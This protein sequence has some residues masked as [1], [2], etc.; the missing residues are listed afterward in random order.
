M[1]LRRDLETVTVEAVFE[2]SYPHIG[3]TCS[4]SVPTARPG[5]DEHCECECHIPLKARLGE[6]LT[7]EGRRALH[8]VELARD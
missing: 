3:R 4:C 2:L 1:A 8:D 6:L 7:A 5:S